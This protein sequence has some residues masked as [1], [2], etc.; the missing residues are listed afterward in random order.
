MKCMSVQLTLSQLVWN[1]RKY[2]LLSELGGVSHLF[3]YLFIV[4]TSYI[5]GLAPT[6]KV[7]AVIIRTSW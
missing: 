7:K 6:Q 2:L 3:I 4:F 5:Y 1:C